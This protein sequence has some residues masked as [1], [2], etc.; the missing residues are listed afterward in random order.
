MAAFVPI[1]LAPFGLDWV[2]DPASKTALPPDYKNKINSFFSAPRRIFSRSGPTYSVGES[3]GKGSY[4]EVFLCK[5]ESDGKDVAIKVLKTRNLD[6]TMTE[7]LI[8]I[9][10]YIYTKDI[11]H[12]E[13]ALEGPYCPA[14]FEIGYDQSEEKLYIVNEIMRSTVLNFFEARKRDKEELRFLVPTVLCQ[15]SMII[16]DLYNIFKFNHRDF[17]TDNIMYIRNH[18]GYPQMRL[19]DFGFSCVNFGNVQI[20]GGGG[21]FKYCSLAT[22]D[23]TQIIF[24]LYKYHKYLPDEIKDI[25]KSL[26][27]FKVG[28]KVCHMYLQCDKMNDWKDTYD[29]LNTDVAN[30][31]GMPDVVFNV[32]ATYLKKGDW[33]SMLAYVPTPSPVLP[34]EL[35][36]VP[37]ICSKGKVHNPNTNRCV[38]ADGALGKALIAAAAAAT[39]RRVA[40]ALVA[41][42]HCSKSKPNYNPLTKR[43]VKACGKGRKRNNT[44]KC[45]KAASI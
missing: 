44:F 37:V 16:I 12:P 17:K 4:G 9:L 25:C 38:K 2:L 14:V 6:N 10:V 5:R 43:C 22:R 45:K 36:A 30:P 32:M 42:K 27:T 15:I 35:P 13:I 40:S 24:E 31:N 7:I 23:M 39:N 19:I 8:Q 3:L 11:K 29:F 33:R 26:L 18:I 21:S 41:I 34:K 20:S 1:N 28:P